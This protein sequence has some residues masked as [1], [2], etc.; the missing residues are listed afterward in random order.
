[1]LPRA[2]DLMQTA[3]T[4]GCFPGGVLLVA[5]GGDIVH[6]QAYGRDSLFDRTP[7]TRQTVFDLASLTKPLATTMA[8]VELARRG[9]VDPDQPL[10]SILPLFNDGM[11]SRIRIRDLLAHTAGFPAWRPYFRK[12][13]DWPPARR[14]AKLK[15]LLAREPLI[16][17]PGQGAVYSDL[18]FMIL[19][20]VVEAATALPLGRFVAEA[21]YRPLQLE[22]DFFFPSLAP[23][24]AGISCAAT[25]LC[26]WRS[27]LLQ[28]VVH[29][30]NAYASGALQGHAGLFGAAMPV[31]RLLTAWMAAYHQQAEHWLPHRWVRTFSRRQGQCQRPLGFDIPSG[32]SPASGGLFSADT[33]GHLG[34]TGASFWMDLAQEVIVILCTNRIHPSRYNTRI[35]AFRP[36]LHDGVMRQLGLVSGKTG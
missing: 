28:G 19:A 29:D 14:P 25:E 27:V 6:F 16:Y 35:R 23:I 13:A 11:K 36:R 31:Y 9:E 5:R 30:D 17:P 1:M 10:A 22:K 26:P 4:T 24:P 12:L 8:F 20:W 32:P 15:H 3:V 33:I 7:M 21:V 2:H 34:F 18:G